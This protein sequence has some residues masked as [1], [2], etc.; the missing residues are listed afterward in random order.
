MRA[1]ARSTRVIAGTAVLAALVLVLDF[2]FKVGNIKL[3]FPIYPKMKFD[4]DGVP[5]VVA[6]LLYGPYS[7]MVTS[8]ITFLTISY[9]DVFSASMKALAE[10]ST[11]VGMIPFYRKTSKSLKAL[12]I[13]FGIT[14]RTVVMS[15]ANLTLLPV[16]STPYFP[17]T[18]AVIAIL[19]FI[20]GFNVA[21]GAISML[22]GY[23]VYEALVKR[24]PMIAQRVRPQMRS[25]V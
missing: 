7:G 19:P 24:V 15:A 14:L 21:A 16:F 4:L 8:V 20:A 2:T 22:G 5:T 1:L 12:A 11:I 13:G 3:P 25:N 18:E 6:L 10:F 9:R 23:F 17:T